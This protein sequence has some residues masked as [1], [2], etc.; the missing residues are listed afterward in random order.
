MQRQKVKERRECIARNEHL[1]G[2]V[3][4]LYK[5]NPNLAT[6]DMCLLSKNRQI[7]GGNFNT[8]PHTGYYLMEDPGGRAL[9]KGG[10]HSCPP[11]VALCF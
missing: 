6:I 7:P 8:H 2:I 10:Q 1:A 11:C 3:H 5:L 9:P 4:T